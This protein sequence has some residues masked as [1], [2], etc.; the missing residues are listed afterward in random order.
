MYT[1]YGGKYTRTMM[2]QMMMAEAGIEYKL[3]EIDMLKQQHRSPEYLAINPAGYIPAMITETGEVLHETHAIALYLVD[4][5]G[6][7]DFGPQVGEE[8]RGSFLT[9]LFFMA[10]D[11]EPILKMVFYPG[12]FVLEPG[13]SARMRQKS[14]QLLLERLQLIENRLQQNGPWYLGERFSFIDIVIAFWTATVEHY[15]A[16]DSLPAIL[17]HKQRVAARPSLRPLFDE[18][19]SSVK[20]FRNLSSGE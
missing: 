9:G 10:D 19:E 15:Q 20:E 5:H 8:L 13:D 12:E 16:H 2:L 6:L 17:Q 7:E 11:I 4:R 18:W 1:L 14:L 3:I